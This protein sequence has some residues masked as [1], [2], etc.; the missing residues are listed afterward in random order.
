MKELKRLFSGLLVLAML[1]TSVPMGQ[2]KASDVV[3]FQE[4]ETLNSS[5]TQIQSIVWQDVEVIEGIDGSEQEWSNPSTGNVE[6]WFKYDVPVKVT[7]TLINGTVEESFYGRMFVSKPL[8]RTIPDNEFID[9]R[10]ELSLTIKEICKEEISF[11]EILNK[12]LNGMEEEI[13]R[14]QKK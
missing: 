14:M 1:V 11:L 10:N 4:T 6:K 13:S 5:A 9:L 3:S 2:V 12:Q 8:V 7:V